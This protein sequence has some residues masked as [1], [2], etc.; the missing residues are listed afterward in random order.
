MAANAIKQ[1]D[2]RTRSMDCNSAVAA[3]CDRSYP[4]PATTD[5][6]PRRPAR[7]R[8]DQT[9]ADAACATMH[10]SQAVSARHE[11]MSNLTELKVA[12]L[13]C[14]ATQVRRFASL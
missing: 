5:T 6:Q 14:F 4:G 3:D 12:A 1:I 2:S 8:R 10:P 9:S 11:A 7:V 13:R